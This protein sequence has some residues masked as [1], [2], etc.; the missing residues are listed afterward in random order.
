MTATRAA[1]WSSRS[2]PASPATPPASRPAW[3][4]LL[5]PAVAEQADELGRPALPHAD[6]GT[7]A[8]GRGFGRRGGDVGLVGPAA[9]VQ[10]ARAALRRPL[11]EVVAG[12]RPGAVRVAPEDVRRGHA[13]A[14][15]HLPHAAQAAAAQRLA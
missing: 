1:S 14:P 9:G 4:E 2:A 7:G 8:L 11:R 5:V 15:Q 13:E 12:P 6:R 3:P 10:Q